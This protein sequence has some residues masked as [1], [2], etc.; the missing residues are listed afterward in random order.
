LEP[1]KD[2]IHVGLRIGDEKSFETET[3]E[4]R[5]VINAAGLYADEVAQLLGPRPWTIYP[6]RG[7]YCEIR[8]KRAE[9]IRDLVYPLPH[10]DGLSLGLHFTKTLWGTTLVGPTAAYVDGKEN[11][12]RDRLTIPEFFED[13]KTMLPDLKESDLQLAY[14]GLRP[15]LL[16]QGVGGFVDFVIEPDRQVP[17]VIQLIGIESPGL[18]SATAIAQHVLGLVKNVLN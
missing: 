7:E 4:A 16:P 6:V 17:Q 18:T 8:G 2:L 11:Y 13:A 10:H 12:E 5:C 9:L 1:R 3:I 14:T 15:K